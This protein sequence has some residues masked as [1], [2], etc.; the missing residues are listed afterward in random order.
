MERARWLEGKRGNG[1]HFL[2]TYLTLYSKEVEWD[3]RCMHDWDGVE[4]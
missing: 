1:G 2:T 4:P 3:E